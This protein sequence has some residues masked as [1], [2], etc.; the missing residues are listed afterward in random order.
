MRKKFSHLRFRM[1]ELLKKI[2]GS[3]ERMN[4]FEIAAVVGVSTRT[5]R[6]WDRSG[7]SGRGTV[8]PRPEIKGRERVYALRRFS[9]AIIEAKGK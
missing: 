3:N 5:I 8:W 4:Q 6:N 1:F 7:L 9:K 2:N